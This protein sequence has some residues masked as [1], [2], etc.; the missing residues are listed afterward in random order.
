MEAILSGF[1]APFPER[2][3]GYGV[4][5]AR[6]EEAHTSLLLG[7]LRE[8]DFRYFPSPPTPWN[9]V[10]MKDWIRRGLAR[11]VPYLVRS[12]GDAVGTTSFLDLRPCDAGVEIGATAY[13]TSVR[14]TFVNPA[15]K[16]L[17]M[18]FAFEQLGLERVQLKCDGRNLASIGAMTKLGAVREGTLRRNTRMADGF[19]R[20][21]VYF[22]VLREEWPA[23]R[24]G[25]EA[26]L[27]EAPR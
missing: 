27:A 19:L 7:C 14:G 12:R 11:S 10:G 2:L 18:G 24:E 5:L 1:D 9:E 16:R 26:R 25:L 8:E 15:C 23:V 4:E 3:A 17:L 20:D 6:L 21:T 22:S 13:A